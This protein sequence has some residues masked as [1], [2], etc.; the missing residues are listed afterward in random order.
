MGK[1]IN[2]GLDIGVQSVGWSIID[3]DTNE[4]IDLGVRLFD[5]VAD[6]KD[7]SL[8]NQKRRDM[9]HARRLI[10]RRK[11]RKHDFGKLVLNY[12]N[13]RFNSLN[14]VQALYDKIDITKFGVDNP[15]ELKVHALTNA[16]RFEQFIFILF[17]YLHQRGYFYLEDEIEN[18]DKKVGN[19]FVINKELT[20]SENL[21]NFYHEY[22]YYKDSP[23]SRS[24]SNNQWEKELNKIF[25]FQKQYANFTI[26][27]EFEEKYMQ[28]FKRH[29]EFSQGPGSEK[30]PSKY[31]MYLPDG[32][33]REGNNLW[34]ALIGKCTY[35]TNEFRGLKNGIAAELFNFFNDLSNI[36]FFNN[37]KIKL[38]IDTK[39]TILKEILKVDTKSFELTPKK[40][41]KLIS[42]KFFEINNIDDKSLTEQDIFG[43]RA[44]HSKK[45]IITKLENFM[46]L[47]NY[48]FS[49]KDKIN[50]PK[51]Y[52]DI[53]AQTP[54][55]ETQMLD[56]IQTI[57]SLFNLLSKD[58]LHIKYTIDPD[59]EK[60]KLIESFTN[61]D[62]LTKFLSNVE[63]NENLSMLN[64]LTKFVQTHSLSDKAMLDYINFFLLNLSLND[65]Q[66]VYFNNNIEKY[67]STKK[68]IATSSG[69]Y[70]DKTIF[71]DEVISPTTRRAFI[72]T[73]LVFNKILKL[74]SKSKYEIDNVTV[75]MPR[76]K[77]T[78]EERKNIE[79]QLDESEKEIKQILSGREDYISR[80]NA[81][82]KQKLKLWNAQGG[83]DLYDG[84]RIDIESILTNPTSYD[85]D[86]IIPYSISLDDSLNN[87]VITKKHLNQAK[88][89]LTPFQAINASHLPIEWTKF[90]N[91]VKQNVKS[92]NKL[93]NLLYKND[94]ETDLLGFTGRHLSDTRYASR[95]VMNTFQAFFADIA[96]MNSKLE[97]HEIIYGNHVKVKVIRGALTSYIRKEYSITK[98]R[99]I[100]CHHAIDAS[101]IA[102]LG[103]DP[104]LRQRLYHFSKEKNVIRYINDETGE[105]IEKPLDFY[106]KE[107][108]SFC[109][110]LKK[111]NATIDKDLEITYDNLAKG[112]KF[113]NIKFSRMYAKR[114]NQSLSNETIYSFKWDDSSK[115]NGHIISKI[116]LLNSEKKILNGYFDDNAKDKK[117]LENHELYNELKQ[118]WNSYNDD[119]N[120][121]PF[122]LY[123]ADKNNIDPNQCSNY[124]YIE[125]EN[126]IKT[127]FLRFKSDPKNAHSILNI[128][129]HDSGGN[130]IGILESLK[131]F[132]MR[133][134]KN[135]KGKLVVVAIN[136]KVVK[137]DKTTNKFKIDK[138]VLQQWLVDN[139]IDN[140]NKYI[141][142][143]KGTIFKNKT[144]GELWYSNGGGTASSNKL[145]LKPLF[146]TLSNRN[147]ITISTINKTY[148]ICE[149]DELGNIYNEKSIED[150][151]A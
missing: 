86:H 149:V 69:K 38:D 37:S 88:T 62:D 58:L 93:S 126:G 36:Y 128:K 120:K 113:T 31:G 5:D 130:K 95:L 151:L 22:G 90:E 74:C 129:A 125:L 77:N 2:I 65:N 97:N 35:Y 26:P 57:N 79:K 110:D 133:V 111:Y 47:K 123:I 124:K 75:E 140:H 24:F 138:A 127:R 1:K 72:Q 54:D 142:V 68:S 147:I 137:F 17:H 145:E 94:P 8:K 83:Y 136:A 76:D 60:I 40:L 106:S 18:K 43:Y 132:T 105:I 7:G 81:L 21:L 102:F 49:N 115:T 148:N 19:T 61:N 107:L 29:R 41:V 13:D 14:E 87:K 78:S 32:T 96:N 25:S 73:V 28:L 48:C 45:P 98:N 52:V 16:I 89:N 50:N 100:Y 67:K 33:K 150:L 99:D 144:T 27:S 139:N 84:N 101:I 3:A 109:A 20:P 141:Q 23:I 51:M 82:T 114:N 55:F 59:S 85:I 53:E 66:Q 143:N 34:D 9:R 4:I 116:D 12:F 91:L 6:N 117:Y 39:K 122:I 42:H 119:T 44:D 64:N 80:I 134:Y 71:D 56:F 121:N 92:N 135:N 118:I 112:D 70:I 104:W 11:T 15:V 63:L 10:S 30:S 46:T 103:A 108:G 146:Y 131:P